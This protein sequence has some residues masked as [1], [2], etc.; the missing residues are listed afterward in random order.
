MFQTEEQ[1]NEYGKNSNRSGMIENSLH[2]LHPKP[3]LVF[4]YAFHTW[5]EQCFMWLKLDSP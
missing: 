2:Y 4:A 5:D 3:R 1:H